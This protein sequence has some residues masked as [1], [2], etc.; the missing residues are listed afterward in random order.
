MH[1]YLG[2]TYGCNS[3]TW[4]YGQLAG[5]KRNG[6]AWISDRLTMHLSRDPMN[7]TTPNVA[8]LLVELPLQL[9]IDP[10][11]TTTWNHFHD[12][13]TPPPPPFDYRSMEDHY[14]T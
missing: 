12:R 8:D 14:T 1:K 2:Q 10:W 9:T 3:V 7:A 4:I 13:L 5:E 11:K 6:V